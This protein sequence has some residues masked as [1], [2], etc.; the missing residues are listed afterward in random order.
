MID[1]IIIYSYSIV[2][3]AGVT[4]GELTA[5]KS[6]TTS[7]IMDILI[8]LP[9]IAGLVFLQIILSKMQSKWPGLVLPVC[10]AII[11][12][13][14]PFTFNIL[15]KFAPGRGRIIVGIIVFVL[16]NIPTLIYIL[17]YFIIRGKKDSTKK[18]QEIQKMNIQDLE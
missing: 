7:I 3:A 11:A 4:T 9:I 2:A 5:Q 17:I 10:S 8:G 14:G 6:F 12:L 1:S 13:F 16:S 18:N 15:F